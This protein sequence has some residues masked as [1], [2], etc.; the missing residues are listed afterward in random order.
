MHPQVV[1]E[2]RCKRQG[3][4]Q[5]DLDTRMPA[6]EGFPLS[7]ITEVTLCGTNFHVVQALGTAGL[8][9]SRRTLLL[10]QCQA[11]QCTNSMHFCLLLSSVTASD[12]CC[13]G[14]CL[15]L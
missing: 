6:Q 10:Y 12:H 9:Q 14:H 15:H 5:H 4:T 13:L 3:A 2:G 1:H 8:P 7:F 11:R